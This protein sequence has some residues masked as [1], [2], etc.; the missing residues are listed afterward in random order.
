M[1]AIDGILRQ[2]KSADIKITFNTDKQ[3]EVILTIGDIHTMTVA[4]D[5]IESSL[6]ELNGLIIEQGMRS[7]LKQAEGYEQK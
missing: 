1:R 6:R 2:F 3:F 7:F 5:T 4:F